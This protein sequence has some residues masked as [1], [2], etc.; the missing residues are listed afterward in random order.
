M[1]NIFFLTLLGLLATGQVQAQ[2]LH[3]I[4][5]GT[6]SAAINSNALLELQSTNK[7]MILP[8]VALTATT[9]P[10]P[11]GA[12]VQGMMVYNTATAND[13]VP[14]QYIN[15]GTQWKR[16]L[17]D[18]QPAYYK[19][20]TWSGSTDQNFP[21]G[22]TNPINVG[23]WTIP[24][25]GKYVVLYH[26]FLREATL[27][28]SSKAFYVLSMLDGLP[29]KIE[30]TF[31]Y[32]DAGGWFASHYSTVIQATKGNVLSFKIAVHASGSAFT[33][34]PATGPRNKFEIYYIGE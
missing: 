31:S 18:V 19:L 22:S 30:E 29:S 23:T 5:D 14:S 9:N 7:G 13:V 1:K 20:L 8:R 17:Q 6:A 11:L 25:T 3:R 15:D 34:Q 24:A 26:S 10:A 2:Q 32:C 33:I 16:I 21:Y 28:A 27:T 4:S 12:H